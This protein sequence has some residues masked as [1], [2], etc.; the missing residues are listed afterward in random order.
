MRVLTVRWLI[1][2]LLVAC[3]VLLSVPASGAINPWDDSPIAARAGPRVFRQG[4]FAD[5][6]ID[7]GGN[8][9]KGHQWAG[10]NPLT[11]PDF[12]KRY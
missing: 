5:E 9:V 4:T 1:A 2:P 10:V 11:T 6:S 7:W 12:P 8:Y 3:A